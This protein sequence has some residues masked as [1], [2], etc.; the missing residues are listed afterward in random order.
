MR[1]RL[2]ALI[3]TVGC[4]AGD[5]N[6]WN[7]P[8]T[9]CRFMLGEP[10]DPHY[11]SW[12]DSYDAVSTLWG[13]PLESM[14]VWIVHS[15]EEMIQIDGNWRTWPECIGGMSFWGNGKSAH[16][17]IGG[18]HCDRVT[19]NIMAHEITHVYWNLREHTEDFHRRCKE[20]I[21]WMDAEEL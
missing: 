15:Q 2:L 18:F 9:G 17:Y 5:V 7:D 19:R 16:I 4:H 11:A 3:L 10:C 6:P 21:E 20:L 12:G 8:V 13:R 1:L 14:S